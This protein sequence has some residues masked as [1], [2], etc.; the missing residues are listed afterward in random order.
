MKP[1]ES[2]LDVTVSLT[3][4]ADVTSSKTLRFSIGA[5]GDIRDVN[6]TELVDVMG[7]TLIQGADEKDEERTLGE[8]DE[9][10]ATE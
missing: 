5:T 2:A 9:N 4:E 1:L 10:I 3:N 6:I 8:T 7:K